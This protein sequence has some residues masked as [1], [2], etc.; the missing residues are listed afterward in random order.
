MLAAAAIAVACPA[1]PLKVLVPVDWTSEPVESQIRELRG[2]RE[3]Y[4]LDRF[5]LIGP[6]NKEYCCGTD[7]SDWER[8]GDAIARARSELQG[9][10][11]V[12]IVY[13]KAKRYASP[14]KTY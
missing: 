6:W 13:P 14:L 9:I 8:L 7:I 10:K 1:D 2:M 12:R 4:G 11:L 3:R 5:V